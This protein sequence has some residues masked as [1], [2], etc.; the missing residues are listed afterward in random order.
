M[1]AE[2]IQ[3][4]KTSLQWDPSAEPIAALFAEACIDTLDRK[5]GIMREAEETPVMRD[6]YLDKMKR[7]AQETK[8]RKGTASTDDGDA[9][10][11]PTR[12]PSA[13]SDAM[14]EVKGSPPN[15]MSGG[16]T[17]NRDGGQDKVVATG[18]HGAVREEVG[19]CTP[20]CCW[21]SDQQNGS[22]SSECT[23]E[24]SPCHTDQYDTMEPPYSRWIAITQRH[25]AES[26]AVS[27]GRRS[28]TGTPQTP[29]KTKPT[30]TLL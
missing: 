22:G 13:P 23:I 18:L 9:A 6:G 28:K 8:R 26:P 25:Q 4:D 20:M 27:E 15:E 10:H 30:S 21:Y 7:L 2:S 1:P 3:Q 11:T 19:G 29:L 12:V 16:D 14:S 5:R 24:I 17:E